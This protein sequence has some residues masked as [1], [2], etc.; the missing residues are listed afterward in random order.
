MSVP[1]PCDPVPAPLG[2]LPPRWGWI[3]LGGGVVAHA[4]TVALGAAPWPGSLVLGAIVALAGLVVAMRSKGRFRADGTALS[5]GAE[6]SRLYVDGLYR[7][8]RNPMYLGLIGVLV[9]VALALGTW[10]PWLAA[11]G[12]AWILGRWF[13]PMEEEHLERAF[14]REWRCYCARVPRWI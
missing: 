6:P 4:A 1:A 14:G 8:S 3:L 11:A 10:G 7:I 9:G 5:P 13:V 2:L 12:Y